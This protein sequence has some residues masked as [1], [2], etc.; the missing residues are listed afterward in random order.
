MFSD[1]AMAWGMLKQ[2][3]IMLFD[4][5]LWTSKPGILN[6]PKISIDA[7]V[8]VHED[9]LEVVMSNWQLAVRKK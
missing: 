6:Q 8:A 3:G 2:G 5:Y 1:A 4:D 7:F 9:Q